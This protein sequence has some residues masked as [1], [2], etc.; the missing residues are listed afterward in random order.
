MIP[1]KPALSWFFEVVA[2]VLSFRRPCGGGVHVTVAA[3][4]AAG[5][6][7]FL[8]SSHCFEFRRNKVRSWLDSIDMAKGGDPKIMNWGCVLPITYFSDETFVQF[9]FSPLNATPNKRGGVDKRAVDERGP[10]VISS[11]KGFSHKR[12]WM[13]KNSPSL[14]CQHCLVKVTSDRKPKLPSFLEL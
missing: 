11:Y 1:P 7:D 2:S 8:G 5:K 9:L 12:V 6:D 13:L 14:L 3:S 10:R 4:M